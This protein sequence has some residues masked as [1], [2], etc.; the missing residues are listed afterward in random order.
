MPS[1]RVRLPWRSGLALALVGLLFWHHVLGVG[2]YAWDTFP[3]IAAGRVRSWSE[4]FGTFT[5]ELMD[6]RFPGGHYYRPLVHLS[7]ALDHALWGL[8]AFGYHLTDLALLVAGALAVAWLVSELLGAGRERWAFLAGLVYLLHPIHLEVLPQPPRR[9]DSMA[10]VATLFA[11][12]CAARARGWSRLPAALLALA[13]AASKETGMLAPL[14]IAGL[15][16][17]SDAAPTASARLRVAL[18]T[19]WPALLL[20]GLFA[21][22]RSYVLGGLGGNPRASVTFDVA[23]LGKSILRYAELVLAPLPPEWLAHGALA[24]GLGLAAAAVLCV[25]LVSRE[26]SA[27]DAPR[28]RT[29]WIL[30]FLLAWLACLLLL[31][32]IAGRNRAWYAL[33]MIAPLALLVGLAGARSAGASGAARLLP[34]AAVLLLFVLQGWGT[35]RAQRWSE[36]DASGRAVAELLERFEHVVATA[37]N[38]TWVEL[39]AYPTGATATRH[40]EATRKPMILGDYSLRSYLELGAQRRAVR[41]EVRR[42]E[43]AAPPGPD[44]LLVLL[45]PRGRAIPID[46]E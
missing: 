3:L 1:E 33:Q 2:L 16:F 40:G 32:T 19:S 29:A 42:P 4:L 21:A 13:A 36:I 43:E 26:P 27:T 39:E 45:V 10:L 6:G 22:W 15:V 12:A 44:E 41:V 31:N 14:L 24:F 38:G 34:A 7:F 35:S 18:R 5:E 9:A 28:Q 11:L 17:A 23:A 37:P 20:V 46:E 8:D 30:A 25:A